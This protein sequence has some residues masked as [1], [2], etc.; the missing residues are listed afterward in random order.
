M[1]RK[2]L[3]GGRDRTKILEKIVRS[4]FRTHLSLSLIAQDDP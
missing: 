3:L 1:R 4:T 2:G